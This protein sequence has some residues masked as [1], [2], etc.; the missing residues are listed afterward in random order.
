LIDEFFH[1]VV[2]ELYG[3][4]KG[5]LPRLRSE[6]GSDLVYIEFQALAEEF[7][8]VGRI[9]RDYRARGKWRV[10]NEPR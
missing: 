4:T 1:D 2:L 8:K 7:K 9:I 10:I 3:S 5:Y 6:R